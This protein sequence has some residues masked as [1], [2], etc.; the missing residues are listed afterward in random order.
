MDVSNVFNEN[1]K[2]F[3]I[4]NSVTSVKSVSRSD[5]VSLF[6]VNIQC[7]S[8]KLDQLSLFLDKYKFDIVCLSEHWLDQCTLES[9][10]IPMYSLANF[11]CREPNKHGGV[12]IFIKKTSILN[13]YILII[14]VVSLMQNSVLLK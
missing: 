7:I 1:F 10:N 4:Q 8:N 14:S 3:D 2:D 9:I 5:T 6:H 13:H 12:L 11:F